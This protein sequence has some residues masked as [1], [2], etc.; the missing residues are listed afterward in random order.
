MATQLIRKS[1]NRFGPWE[2]LYLFDCHDPFRGRTLR[3]PFMITEIKHQSNETVTFLARRIVSLA[4]GGQPNL[5][6]VSST[7]WS[8]AGPPRCIG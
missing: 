6:W 7:C 2:V 5:A 1:A 3:G 8:S 4:A